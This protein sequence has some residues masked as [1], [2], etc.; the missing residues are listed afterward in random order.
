VPRV[1]LYLGFGEIQVH[2][3]PQ[4]KARGSAPGPRWGRRPQAPF[5]RR[6]ADAAL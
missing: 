6:C 1:A 4:E 2:R 3:K 5:I